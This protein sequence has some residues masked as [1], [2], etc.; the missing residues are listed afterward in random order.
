MLAGVL[1][2]SD[3]LNQKH[4]FVMSWNAAFNELLNDTCFNTQ[5]HTHRGSDTNST[6]NA[7]LAGGMHC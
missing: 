2:P 6:A 3:P 1:S 5:T 4:L 7:T